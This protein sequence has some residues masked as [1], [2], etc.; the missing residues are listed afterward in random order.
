MQW[1]SDVKRISDVYDSSYSMWGSN[2]VELIDPNQGY[3]GDCWIVAAASC[4]AQTPHRIKKLFV[5]DHLNDAGVYSVT[6]YL[7]G[8]PVTVTVDDYLPFWEGSNTLTYSSVSSDNALWMP[9]LEKAAAKLYGNYG[10]L[11]GGWMGPAIQTLTGSPFFDVYHSEM[12]VD[13]LWDW[14]SEKMNDEWMI[15]ASTPYGNGTDQQ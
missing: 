10:M 5:T 14:V 8:M 13:E 2:G 11:S 7:M 6:L 3:L 15:T 12:T 1:Q 9:I 4:V